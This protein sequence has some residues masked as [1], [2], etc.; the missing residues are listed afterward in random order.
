MLTNVVELELSN[1]V[2]IYSAVNMS[3][4]ILYKR[5]IESQKLKSPLL[6]EIY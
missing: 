1:L 4:L 6:V 2:K 3:R 5:Q